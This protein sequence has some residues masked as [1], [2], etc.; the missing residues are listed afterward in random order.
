M[1]KELILPTFSASE[2]GLGFDKIVREIHSLNQIFSSELAKGLSMQ[3]LGSL[4]RRLGRADQPWEAFVAKGEALHQYVGEKLYGP[5]VVGYVNWVRKNCG[6]MGYKGNVYF[7]LRDATPLETAAEIV[8]EGSDLHPVGVYAN[9][10]ILGIA[11]E[12][13]A[14][15]IQNNQAGLKYLES[16]GLCQNRD[17]VWADSGAWGTVVKLMK[18]TILMNTKLYPFFWYSHNPHIPGYLNSLRGEAGLPEKMLE[19][20]NNSLECMFPQLYQRPVQIENNGNGPEVVLVPSTTLA[21]AWG[22]AALE[23]ISKAAS[24]LKGNLSHSEEVIQLKMLA[25]LSKTTLI[26]NE[27][28]G[29]LPHNTPTWSHGPQFLANW[30]L[31]LLP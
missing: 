22:K 20:I 24:N 4:L 25:E 21:V 12:M 26:T 29:V 27:W 31:D 15:Q 30:P 23:G 19:T 13:V 5:L 10:P 18:Q 28:A 1:I 14:G 9:R 6:E 11:D 16:K 7:A 8:W 17:V 2:D 3:Y